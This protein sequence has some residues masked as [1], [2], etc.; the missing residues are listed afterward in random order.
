MFRWSGSLKRQSLRVKLMNSRR[1][2]TNCYFFIF[3]ISD[4]LIAIAWLVHGWWMLCRIWNSFTAFC[5][6]SNVKPSTFKTFLQSGNSRHFVDDFVCNGWFLFGFKVC[7]I[8]NSNEA[9]IF[10]FYNF[11]WELIHFFKRMIKF[12]W[13]LFGQ[14][15]ILKLTN[16]KSI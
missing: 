4:V 3:C 1:I 10:I 7:F 5:M 12:N 6:S 14:L 13:K 9:V 16:W 11:F 2:A 8:I 15:N